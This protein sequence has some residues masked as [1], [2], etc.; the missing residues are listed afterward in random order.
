MAGMEDI[1]KYMTEKAV[2]FIETPK[3]NRIQ[4]KES[5]KRN[6]EPWTSRWFGMVPFAVHMWYDHLRNKKRY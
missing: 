1:V 5:R 6:K 2:A 4:Q 3:E